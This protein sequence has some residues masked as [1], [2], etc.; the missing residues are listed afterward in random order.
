MR[1]G[2]RKS[3]VLDPFNGHATLTTGLISYWKMDETDGTRS[4]SVGSN[5][6]TDNNTVVGAAAKRSLGALFVAANDES[7][8][9]SSV[10]GP[11]GDFSTSF[12]ANF[13]SFPE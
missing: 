3:G 2:F 10:A 5:H 9:R 13:N 1:L 7:L 4:D 12:W 11:T 8:T 6:L